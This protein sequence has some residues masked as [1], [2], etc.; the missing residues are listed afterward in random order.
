MKSK[1]PSVHARTDGSPPNNWVSVFGGSAWEWDP[2]TSQF[3]YHAYLKE[4][5]DLNWRNPA[6]QAAML[7]VLRFWFERGVDGM[8][9]DALRQI[10]KDV[11][12]RDN[13]PN[14]SYRSGLPEYDSLLPVRSADHDDLVTLVAGAHDVIGHGADA[15]GVG[16]GRAAELLDDEAHGGVHRTKECRDR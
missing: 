11:Q 7:D 1:C 10:V 4:Q 5:P 2:A 9:I 14:P 13:P 15:I 6:V 16:D 12:L 3:Y 8:R